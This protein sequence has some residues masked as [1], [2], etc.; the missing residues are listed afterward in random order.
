M[1]RAGKILGVDKKRARPPKAGPRQAKESEMEAADGIAPEELKPKDPTKAVI[2]AEVE[3]P[4]KAAVV[5]AAQVHN[6][7]MVG[8][9]IQALQEYLV[10]HGMWPPI[11]EG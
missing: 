3:K 6:R 7:K 5:R 4:L 2:Y 11:T 10:R 8:E 9:V 1:A